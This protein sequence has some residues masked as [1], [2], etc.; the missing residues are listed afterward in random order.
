[1]LCG[2]VSRLP[3]AFQRRVAIALSS[4]WC[5]IGSAWST[6]AASH[7]IMNLVCIA[8][9]THGNRLNFGRRKSM[10][11][12]LYSEIELGN[13]RRSSINMKKHSHPCHRLRALPPPTKLHSASALVASTSLRFHPIYLTSSSLLTLPYHFLILSIIWRLERLPFVRTPYGVSN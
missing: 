4:S 2:A 5:S 1:V 10:T 3:Y 11:R 9:R 13:T 6:S 12:V 7:P 8:R